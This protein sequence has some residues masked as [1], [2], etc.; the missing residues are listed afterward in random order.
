MLLKESIPQSVYGFLAAREN[1]PSYTVDLALRSDITEHRQFGEQWFI[2]GQGKIFILSVDA[3]QAVKP[4]F[5]FRFNEIREIKSYPVVGG[6]ILEI[7]TG[8][9]IYEVMHYSNAVA[10]RFSLAVKL[11][12][13]MLRHPDRRINEEMIDEEIAKIEKA[14]PK[15]LSREEKHEVAGRLFLLA[16][17]YLGACIVMFMLLLVGV[18]IDLIPPYLTKVLVD[19]V[20]G[21]SARHADWLLWLVLGLLGLR[22]VR[23]VITVVNNRLNAVIGS[24][25]VFNLRAALFEKLQRIP[26]DYFDRKQ[27][28]GLMT[29]VSG[30]S[31]VLQG[32]ISN[33]SQGFL[34][35]IVLVLGIGAMLFSMNWRLALFVLLPGP[36]VILVTWRYWRYIFRFHNRYWFSRFRLSS[37]LNTRLTGIRV[38]R[39]FNQEA[40]EIGAFRT[41]SSRLR[42]DALA[43][44]RSWMTFFPV[45][46]FVFGLGGLLVWYVGGKFVLSENPQYHISLGTL[47]AFLSYLGMF[48]GPLS[49]LTQLGNWTTQ[50]L[51][52]GHRIFDIFDETE[53][54][55]H[56]ES[57]V[58]VRSLKGKVEFRDVTFGYLNYLPVLQNVSFTVKPG[59]MMGII[60]PSGS[61][62]TTL[63]NLLCR[64]YIAGEGQV[65]VDDVDV[66]AI[67][68]DDLRGHIGLVPQE[69][70][71]FRGTI[72]ENIAYAKPRAGIEE[73]VKAAK[74]ANAHDFILRMPDSY[75]TR[76][77]EGGAG[78]SGGE[79]QRIS[80][81]RAI[82]RNPRILILDEAT[83]SVDVETERLIQDALKNLVK[84]RTTFLIAHRLSTLQ[85]VDRIAVIQNGLLKQFGRPED[86][87]REDGYYRR[88]V[89]TQTEFLRLKQGFEVRPEGLPPVH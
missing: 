61:G 85:N 58:R 89:Q 69:P 65:L 84:D 74:A 11:I 80:I 20:L 59:E 49:S 39:A 60:G 71:L 25:F 29:R 19:D 47:I 50:V 53:E 83:S 23:I 7:K 55:V 34:L 75:E 21:A 72:E 1:V 16:R 77:G 31:E 3:H 38:I 82:L 44:N 9:G 76:I 30:D 15:E 36:F 12:R 56:E 42:E 32:F 87:M 18:G 52:A 46:S 27:V 73:I 81:A 8:D 66:R 67:D 78:L 2:L 37:F 68:K 86:L 24:R 43:I 35:N 5:E 51:T 40:R 14:K 79:R 70:Y 10:D 17:P 28:G 13:N 26:I 22:V 88:F 4:L 33:I 63:I 48:Y 57:S 45:L 64:F 6:Q 54:T 62:K 41:R